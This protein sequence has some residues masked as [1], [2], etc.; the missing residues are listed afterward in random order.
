MTQVA[1]PRRLIKTMHEYGVEIV[2]E[3]ALSFK[4]RLASNFGRNPS[5]HQILSHGSPFSLD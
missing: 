2:W 3:F 1:L 4:W 5:I